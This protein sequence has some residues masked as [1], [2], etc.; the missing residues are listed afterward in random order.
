MA[1]G[2]AASQT[3]CQL[4]LQNFEAYMNASEFEQVS[5]L[6]W[7]WLDDHENVNFHLMKKTGLKESKVSS[8]GKWGEPALKTLLG[9][10]VSQVVGWV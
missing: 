1:S 6:A 8:W 5:P 2:F 7:T 3:D 4:L 9:D 10:K